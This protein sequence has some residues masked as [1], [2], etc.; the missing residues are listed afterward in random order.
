MIIQ[1]MSKKALKYGLFVLLTNSL[2]G[3]IIRCR[4]VLCAINL[5]SIVSH[6]RYD[7]ER[8]RGQKLYD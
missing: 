1:N 8:D 6:F 2:D 7:A 4:L 5:S 3:C